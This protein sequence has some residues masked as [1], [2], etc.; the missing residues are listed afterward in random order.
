MLPQHTTMQHRA[1]AGRHVGACA[2]TVLALLRLL[3]HL[4]L[5]LLLRCRRICIRLHLQ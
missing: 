3:L 5:R 4:L 1:G 2:A